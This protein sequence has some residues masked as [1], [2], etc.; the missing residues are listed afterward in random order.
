[1]WQRQQ[2]YIDEYIYQNTSANC[3]QSVGI[4]RTSDFSKKKILILFV[5]FIF[6]ISNYQ[7]NVSRNETWSTS[8]FVFEKI[9]VIKWIYYN[10]E[11]ITYVV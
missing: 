5:F 2:C 4:R 9:F 1:M 7:I 3:Y 8:N 6:K 10:Y 11:I